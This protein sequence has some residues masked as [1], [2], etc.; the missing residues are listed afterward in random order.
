ME[1]INLYSRGGERE[2][3]SAV[4]DS[5]TVILLREAAAAPYEVL[6]MRRRRN[7]SFMAGAHVFPGGSLEDADKGPELAACL[8]GVHSADAKR[9]LQE[10]DLPEETARGLFVAAVRETFEEA[11]VLLARDARGRLVDL[12]DP[13]MLSRFAAYRL[14]LHGSEI[15]LAQ[16]LRREGLSLALDLLVPYAHW[17]TPE[18]DSRR[19]STRFFLARLPEGQTPVHDRMELAESCW[20]TP[21]FALAEHG[22]GRIVLM[23]P[24][25]KTVEELLAFPDIG[26]LFDVARSRRI[27]AVLP[28]AV[29]TVD[30]FRLLLPHDPEYTLDGYRQPPH[31]GETTRIVMEGGIWKTG[32]A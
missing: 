31:R 4:R 13:G 18:V 19:F 8:G 2:H 25:L 6:L 32:T 30:G 7:Q 16:L 23:P 3:G 14:A 17:I 21:R 10:P 11:G 9:L 28:Q 1:K 24:T 22:A 12:S 26:R 15:T 29:R 27:F 5:A 20:M